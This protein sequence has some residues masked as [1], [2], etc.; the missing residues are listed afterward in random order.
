M[1]R[2]LAVALLALLAPLVAEALVGDVPLSV[3]GVVIFVSLL[4]I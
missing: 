4:P 1:K 3:E 2:F